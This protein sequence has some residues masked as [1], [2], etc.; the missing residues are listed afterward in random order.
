LS[1]VNEDTA[2]VLADGT[3]HTAKTRNNNNNNNRREEPH[4]SRFR[5]I[6]VFPVRYE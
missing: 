3:V 2:I 4:N 5:A 1:I 6:S